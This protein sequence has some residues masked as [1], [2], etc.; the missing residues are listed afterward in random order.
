LASLTMNLG[1]RGNKPL[2]LA[3]DEEIEIFEHDGSD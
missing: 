2:L 1:S 3:V